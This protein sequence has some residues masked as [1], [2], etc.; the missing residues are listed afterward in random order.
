[1]SLG[2]VRTKNKVVLRLA[3]MVE[4]IHNRERRAMIF[5][6]MAMRSIE[7]M[8]YS[9]RIPKKKVMLRLTVKVGQLQ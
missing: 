8:S 6:N 2:V 7:E 4:P 3:V 9:I 5:I 1:M